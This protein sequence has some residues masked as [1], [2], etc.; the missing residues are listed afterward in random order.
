LGGR[1]KDGWGSVGF[2]RNNGGVL[3]IAFDQR[4]RGLGSL[5]ILSVFSFFFFLIE[6]S[7]LLIIKHQY[8]EFTGCNP[9]Q[10]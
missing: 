7:A 1:R 5:E 6:N 9:E 3:V 8:K 10:N 2:E 4:S